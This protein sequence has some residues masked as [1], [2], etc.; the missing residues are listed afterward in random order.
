M[1]DLNKDIKIEVYINVAGKRRALANIIVG[2]LIK[3]NNFE[4]I[5]EPNGKVYVVNPH[6]ISNVYNKYNNM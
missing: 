6:I 5:Q 3:V 2:D 1:L 4:I